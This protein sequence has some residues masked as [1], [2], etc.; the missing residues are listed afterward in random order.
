VAF[1]FFREGGE[2]GGKKKSWHLS[3]FDNFSG[4]VAFE[5]LKYFF[6]A[7]QSFMII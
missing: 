6:V 1:E 3:H 4:F 5:S 7:F 2:K